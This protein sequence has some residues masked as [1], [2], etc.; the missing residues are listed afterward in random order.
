MHLGMH[1]VGA[2]EC[3]DGPFSAMHGQCETKVSDGGKILRYVDA[4][5]RCE[6]ALHDDAMAGQAGARL[7]LLVGESEGKGVWNRTFTVSEDSVGSLC[8]PMSTS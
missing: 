4:V 6:A 8:N 1:L 7:S 5:R 2:R 3:S